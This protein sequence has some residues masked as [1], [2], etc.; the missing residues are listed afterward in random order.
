MEIGRREVGLKNSVSLS[1]NKVLG[2]NSSHH[3]L[4][5]KPLL[6]ATDGLLL[7]ITL[8]LGPLNT[9]V[10]DEY[11][12]FLYFLRHQNGSA[13]HLKTLKIAVSRDRN[14]E[15]DNSCASNKPEY[16]PN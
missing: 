7:R 9:F 1:Q 10:F 11:I 13:E 16:A 8:V 5:F 2:T 14:F 4:M 6:T 15:F 12:F 3:I